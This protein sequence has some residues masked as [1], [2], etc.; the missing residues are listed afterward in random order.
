M[1]HEDRGL[2]LNQYDTTQ[3]ISYRF[4]TNRCSTIS[5]Q[6]G[7]LVGAVHK[8]SFD[9]GSNEFK[10]VYSVAL[11]LGKWEITGEDKHHTVT[12]KRIG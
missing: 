3:R 4:D 11:P 1:I 2:V 12:L 6:N 5:I 9:N 10:V 7:V 8:T